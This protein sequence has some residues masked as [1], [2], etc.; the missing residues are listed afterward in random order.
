MDSSF[1][2]QPD[3]FG[4]SLELH[5]ESELSE[6]LLYCLNGNMPEDFVANPEHA[7]RKRA[8]SEINLCANEQQS[9]KFFSLEIGKDELPCSVLPGETSL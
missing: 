5:S 1:S 4:S 6:S 2:S 7:S 9:K 3:D 8:A